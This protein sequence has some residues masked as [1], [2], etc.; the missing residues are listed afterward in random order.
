MIEVQIEVRKL[1]DSAIV[2][3]RMTEGLQAS[4]CTQLIM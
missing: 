2:P 1:N 4:I 3:Q